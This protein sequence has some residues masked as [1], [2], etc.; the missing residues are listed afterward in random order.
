MKSSFK[1]SWVGRRLLKTF[2]RV[3]IH[4]VDNWKIQDRRQKRNLNNTGL[5][6]FLFEKD[7]TFHASALSRY[8][9]SLMKNRLRRTEDW[10]RLTCTCTMYIFSNRDKQISAS[11]N[12]SHHK[13]H[14]QISFFCNSASSISQLINTW[15]CSYSVFRP[16]LESRNLC[17]FFTAVSIQTRKTL[18]LKFR[19]INDW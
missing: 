10:R 8:S 5:K 17:N 2:A 4:E 3:M 18:S 19:W 7:C 1:S 11:S 13:R 12:Q 6:A 16:V 14:L 9:M 15:V